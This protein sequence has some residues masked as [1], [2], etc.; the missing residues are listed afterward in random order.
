M[1]SVAAQSVEESL[2]K[3]GPLQN[4]GR[5]KE[6]QRHSAVAVALQKGHQETETDEHHHVHVLKH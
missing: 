3:S 1:F 6:V 2:T 5:N 4:D